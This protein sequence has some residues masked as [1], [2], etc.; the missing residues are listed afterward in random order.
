MIETGRVVAMTADSLIRSRIE[1]AARGRNIVVDVVLS[2]AELEQ[3]APGARVVLLDLAHDGVDLAEI[4]AAAHEGAGIPVVAFAADL[5]GVDVEGAREAGCD[6][7]MTS[8]EL[9]L[10][11]PNLLGY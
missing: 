10:R 11:L 1:A 9:E 6:A 8:H 5:A 2:Q 4:V 3:V 7:V